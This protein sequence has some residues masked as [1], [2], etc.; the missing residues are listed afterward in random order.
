MLLLRSA[1]LYIHVSVCVCVC[2]HEANSYTVLGT[3]PCF[4]KIKGAFDQIMPSDQPFTHSR[5]HRR[6]KSHRIHSH[7]RTNTHTHTR[8]Y[9]WL[10]VRRWDFYLFNYLSIRRAHTHSFAVI[11]VHMSRASNTSDLT[12]PSELHCS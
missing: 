11:A 4:H 5:V 3:G 12:F 9:M 8:L 10:C 2:V 1:R 7:G 6:P